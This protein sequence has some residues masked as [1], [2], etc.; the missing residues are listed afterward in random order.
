MLKIIGRI[1]VILLVSGLIAGGIYLIV[2]YDPAALGLANQRAGFE[3]QIRNNFTG[4]NNNGTASPLAASGTGG[5]PTR[6][7][8]GERDF[9]GRISISRGL[10]GIAGN[11]ILFSAITL[12]V[13]AV[14]RIYSSDWR[15]RPVRAG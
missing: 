7:R 13:V 5:Q 2:Q 8:G 12:L 4:I 1:L 9:E 15:K 3:G 10:L 14:Q 11:L 6:F